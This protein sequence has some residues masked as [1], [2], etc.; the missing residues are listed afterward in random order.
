MSLTT[1]AQNN[2][3]DALTIT[4]A[5]LH[6]GFP[7]LTGASELAGGTYARKVITFAAA[8][9]STRIT[10]GPVTFDTPPASTV[11]WVG[12]WNGGTFI[13]YS[14]SGGNPKEFVAI[15]STDTIYSTAHGYADTNTIVFFT[16]TVPAGLAEGTVYYVRDAT[17]DT[18]KVATTAGGVA[19]DLTTAGS[20]DC[21]VSLIVQEVYTLAG[22][23]TLS[24]ASIG[25]PF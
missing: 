8:S 11:R 3:L 10:S 14:P 6:S 12:F 7:G 23:H 20:T 15:P 22:T 5:S 18:F 19:I 24:S 16:G 17:A 21:Q 25:L 2:M 13:G 4:D 1:A 9:G